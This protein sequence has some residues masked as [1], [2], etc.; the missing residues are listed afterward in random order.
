MQRRRG[1]RIRFASVLVALGVYSGLAVLVNLDVWS[2]PRARFTGGGGD[3]Q[4]TMWFLNWTPY[5]VSHLH[6]PLISTYLN[7]P[8]GF[9]LLWNTAVPAA[10]MLLWPVT[11]VWGAPATYNVLMTASVALSALIAFLVIRRYVP[12]NL[13]A[14]LG[15]LLYGFS[16]YMMAQS[17]GHAHVVVSA[18]TPPLALL[19][20]DEALIR[21]RLRRWV[22]ATLIVVLAVVQFFLAEEVFVTEIISG[23]VLAVVLALTHRSEWRAHLPYAA[24][25]LG[26]AAGVTAL[27]LAYPVWV[28]LFGPDRLPGGA[29]HSPDIFL[30][31]PLNLVVPTTVQFF[32]PGLATTISDHFSGNG[33]ESNGYLG[34]PLLLAMLYTLVRFWKVS[35]VRVAGLCAVVV[36]VFSLGP[37]LHLDGHRTPIPLP[38]WLPS[39]LPLIESVQ[40]NRLMVYAFL[41]AAIGLAF[42]LHR[43]WLARRNVFISAGLLALLLAPLIP[44]VPLPSTPLSIPAYFSSAAVAEIPDG[45]VVLTAPWPGQDAT[46]PMLWQVAA[47]MRFRLVGG[48]FLGDEAPQTTLLKS[49]VRGI[50]SGSATPNVDS[51]T[52]ATLLSELRDA[53]IGAAIAGPSAHHEAMIAF[54]AALLGAPA[55]THAGVSVWLMPGH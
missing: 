7:Y 25:V 27:L 48:Y 9:N 17:L 43:L 30:T 37:H 16:P 26:A 14:G 34:I 22:L 29:I 10:G 24:R 12:G 1:L 44:K 13:A 46:D 41:A 33:V 55:E 53:N 4:Q 39:K 6:N 45:T 32:S 42:I 50:R 11:A 35:L 19:L 51:A 23:A 8:K 2:D 18:I 28:Q 52:R 20:I 47:G 49:I 5:A 15:G 31:D 38:W 3:P 21:Q 40:P 36:I 54:F